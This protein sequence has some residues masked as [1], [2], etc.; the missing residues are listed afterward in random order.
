MKPLALSIAKPDQET[1]NED[2]AFASPLKIAVSDGAGGGGLYAEKWSAYLIEN[3]P[4]QALTSYN[5]LDVWIETI[6]EAFYN[7]CEDIAK[8]SGGLLLDKFYN[9][10]SFATLVAAWKESNS[11]IRWMSYGD[12]VVFHY[13]TVADILDHS[14][15]SLSDF[16]NPPFLINSKDPLNKK[17]YRSGLFNI[18]EGSIVFCT[19][20]AL[21]FY[22]LLLYELSQYCEYHSDLEKLEQSNNKNT[23]LLKNAMAQKVDFKT[24]I[25]KLLNCRSKIN[26]ERHIRKL[27]KYGL[28]SLDDYSIAILQ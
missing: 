5:Q 11:I 20:D 7:D 22:I 17:G 6:W 28:I 12:S 16:D 2:A 21:A 24:S 15:S 4:D 18:T 1:I 26:F 19:S 9:E 25:K 14:F 27:L 13:N 3:I 23:Q 8:Q 10:G